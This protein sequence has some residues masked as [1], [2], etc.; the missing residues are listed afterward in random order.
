M[1]GVEALERVARYSYP[2]FKSHPV[3]RSFW[4]MM[5][6]RF[7]E[8]TRSKFLSF[9]WGKTRLPANLADLAK[10]EDVFTI[11]FRHSAHPGM[12]M[13][14]RRMSVYRVLWMMIH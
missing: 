6:T 5:K 7:D 4:E 1:E 8:A 9:V 2:Y 10:L 3:I 11:D 12:C 13:H 14:T